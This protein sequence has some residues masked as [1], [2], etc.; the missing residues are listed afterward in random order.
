MIDSYTDGLSVPKEFIQNADD[1]HATQV[2]FLY[3]ERK[4]NDAKQPIRQKHTKIL[5]QMSV[6]PT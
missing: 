4:N 1:A 6:A 2:S 3:D 5:R